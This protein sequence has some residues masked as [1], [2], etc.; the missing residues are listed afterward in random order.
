MVDKPNDRRSAS[1]N[2]D[3]CGHH[4]STEEHYQKALQEM[5]A[6]SVRYIEAES[7]SRTIFRL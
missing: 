1:I 6:K 5:S 2:S 7:S 3:F 4:A